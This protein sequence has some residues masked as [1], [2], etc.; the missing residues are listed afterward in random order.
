MK[1]FD[2]LP[3]PRLIVAAAVVVAG[4]A[5][6]AVRYYSL[7][8]PLPEGQGADTRTA[9]TG[10]AGSGAGSA[11]GATGGNGGGA[12]VH[13]DVAPVGVPE[14]LAR[15]QMLVRNAGGGDK[16][17]VGP[18]VAV[19]EE[20]RWASSL[21][22]ELR[23]AFAGAIASKAGAIDVTRGGRLPG[24]PV[25]RIAIRVGHL[26]PVLD[27][28]VDAVFGWTI[29]RSDDS[30]YAICEVAVSRPAG[31]GMDALVEAV[32]ETVAVAAGK[33][34]DQIGQLQA[35]GTAACD[36]GAEASD[37][38][39][40]AA[41]L[42]ASAAPVSGVPAT[43]GAASSGRAASKS[44]AGAPAK[45]PASVTAPSSRARAAPRTAARPA[46]VTRPV[47]PPVKGSS[48]R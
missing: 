34:A 10:A 8:G 14:R 20:Q 40:T 41:S 33:I 23:D 7:A 24:R 31:R 42:P 11:S 28:Q 46:A 17:P 15:P 19:L 25:Y 3:S 29:T 43:P 21:D 6:P 39:G 37:R 45:V 35:S 16:E 38:A 4:C 27:R 12:A 30:R 13:I 9:G 44:P 48:S 22:S 36:S 5:A 47:A 26:D 18:Q 1:V 32:K 2:G